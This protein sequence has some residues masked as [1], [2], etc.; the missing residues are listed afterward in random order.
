[1]DTFNFS[2]QLYSHCQG[3]EKQKRRSSTYAKFVEVDHGTLLT[4]GMA[5]RGWDIPGVHWII[6]YDPPHKP[7]VQ[8]VLVFVLVDDVLYIN[9]CFFLSIC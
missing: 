1:M 2:W 4:T 9:Y 7:E 3:Q 5:E 8:Y 6:Q